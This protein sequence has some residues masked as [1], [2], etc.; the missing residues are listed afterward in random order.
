M[1]ASKT[2]SRY[3][4]KMSS[5]HVFK[6]SSRRLQ[7][8]NFPSYKTSSRRLETFLQGV[9]QT[10]SRHICKTS[11][12][13]RLGR[14]KIV[15]LKTCWRRLQDVLKTNKCSLGYASNACWV[16]HSLANIWMTS[17]DFWQIIILKNFGCEKTDAVSKQYQ[18]TWEMVIQTCLYSLEKWPLNST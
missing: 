6:R 16:N 17:L 18:K 10:S 12:R 13:R 2:S 4:L 11:S 14:R 5:R 3:V 1:C 7:R 15:T 8:N 9:Y